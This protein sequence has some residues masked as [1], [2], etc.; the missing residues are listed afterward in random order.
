MSLKRALKR[1][2]KNIKN[3]SESMLFQKYLRY[4]EF[5]KFKS[6]KRKAIYSKVNLSKVQKKQIDDFFVENYGEKIS[7]IWHKHYTAFTGSFDYKYIPEFMYIPEFEYF[8]N[9]YKEYSKVFEDK[10]ILPMMAKMINVKTPK[11]I[12]KSIKGYCL[13]GENN[14]LEKDELF[15]LLNIKG[16][17]FLKPTVDTCS[18][19]GCRLIEVK[20]GIDIKSGE[21]ITD[22]F[23]DIGEDYVVQ[24]KISCHKSI[25]AINETSVNTFRVITYR[26]LNDIHILPVIMRFGM[27]DSVVDNAHAG[28]A[29]IAINNDGTLH[30]KAFTEFNSQYMIHPN[31]KVVFKNHK[32]DCFDKVLKAAKTCHESLS[33]IGVVNWDFTINEEGEPILI[34][35]N[36]NG[37]SIWLLEMAWGKGPFGENTANVLK[38]LK[39]MKTLPASEWGKHHF[40]KM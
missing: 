32:I 34:E 24:E 21:K 36:V 1:K 31:S 11:V 19:V 38:W 7:Y 22:I 40:G 3:N 35:A 20:N 14:H 15:E 4:S 6:P 33:M 2:L 37:G 17:V 8:M 9:Q 10:N 18:G 12:V 13:D 26:W 28:G 30:E 39:L 25:K 23:S 27:N 29:F 5:K 16:E